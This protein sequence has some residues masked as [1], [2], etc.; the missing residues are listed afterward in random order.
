M[1]K[2]PGCGGWGRNGQSCRP[3]RDTDHA[4]ALERERIAAWLDRAWPSE[5]VSTDGRYK[6]QFMREYGNVIRSGMHHE[7]GL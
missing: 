6:I 5:L 4:V 7:E 2:C 3:C 1:H